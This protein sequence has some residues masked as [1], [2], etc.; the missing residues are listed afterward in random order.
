MISIFGGK[1]VHLSENVTYNYAIFSGKAAPVNFKSEPVSNM[2]DTHHMEWVA[3]SQSPI[4]SFKFQYKKQTDDYY[5]ANM[6]VVDDGKDWTEVEITPKSNGDNFYSG[7][8]TLKNLQPAT[9]YLARVSSSNDY[10]FNKF[11]QPFQFATK[12]AGKKNNFFTPFLFYF[13]F[14]KSYHLQI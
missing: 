9:R 6:I 1:F 14:D 8:Y 10:G 13:I 12:G 4:T 3:E 2:D 11:S 5:R 7:K